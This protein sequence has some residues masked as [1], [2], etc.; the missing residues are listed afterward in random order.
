MK[1]D[2]LL[3]YPNQAA[4]LIGVRTTKF[5]ELRKL[6]DFPKPRNLLG[7]RPMYVR[8][9]IEDWAKSLEVEVAH[10]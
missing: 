5:Y 8:Q 6:S 2:P 3:L 10:D 9:E 4:A 1:Q 7:K